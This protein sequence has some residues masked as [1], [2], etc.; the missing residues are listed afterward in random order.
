MELPVPPYPL[1]VTVWPKAMGGE[2]MSA[3]S[4]SNENARISGANLVLL[5][6][7]MVRTENIDLTGR[8]SDC[9]ASAAYRRV[10]EIFKA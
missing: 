5:A 6:R 10:P 9:G 3:N 4:V 1:L 2:N 7:L 8:H